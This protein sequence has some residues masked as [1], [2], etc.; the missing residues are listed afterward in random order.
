MLDYVALI[1]LFPASWICHKSVLREANGQRGGGLHRLRGHRAL[2]RSFR[3]SCSMRLLQLPPAQRSAERILYTWITPV[4]FQA[5]IGFLVDP[6]SLV[7]MM[8]VSGVSFVIHIYSHGYMHDDPDYPALLHLSEPLRLLHAHPGLGQ[9]FPAH[10]RGVGRRGALLVLPDR[11]LVREEIGLGR[12]ARKLS[13]S[14]GSGTTASC[15]PS[16]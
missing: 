4:N 10:V 11:L 14:T 8:V 9:Q 7:M 15:W 12:R 5:N 2:L 1:P 13:S 3:F 16:S 6:L